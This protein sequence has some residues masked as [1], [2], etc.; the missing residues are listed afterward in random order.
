MLLDRTKPIKSV[1]MTRTKEFIRDLLLIEFDDGLSMIYAVS[2]LA[3][4]IFDENV[5]H[6]CKLQIF[7][8]MMEQCFTQM[9]ACS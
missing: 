2:I 6:S 4:E 8:P 5:V 1:Q 7:D 9:E 3:L